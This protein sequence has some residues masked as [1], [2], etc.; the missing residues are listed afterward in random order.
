[1]WPDWSGSRATVKLADLCAARWRGHG[2]RKKVREK[3]KP[4][5]LAFWKAKASMKSGFWVGGAKAAA[6]REE[7][8][9]FW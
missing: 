9:G 5:Q 6:D 7:A 1:L 4:F 3:R 8:E 2:R